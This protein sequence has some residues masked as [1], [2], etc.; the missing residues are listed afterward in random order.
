MCWRESNKSWSLMPGTWDQVGG[1]EKGTE[2]SSQRGGLCLKG[3]FVPSALMSG[4]K[5]F[6]K[7][8]IMKPSECTGEESIW[9]LLWG[10]RPTLHC[11]TFAF[12]SGPV[13]ISLI[14]IWGGITMSH[15]CGNSC[16]TEQWLSEKH[17]HFL[18]LVPK[19]GIGV[20]IEKKNS[21]LSK[22]PRNKGFK[23]QRWEKV[24]LSPVRIAS[25]E[26]PCPHVTD[27][28]RPPANMLNYSLVEDNGEPLSWR[29]R[30]KRQCPSQ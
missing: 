14:G 1:R 17:S 21:N 20:Y 10:D 3:S 18:P 16:C 28:I 27:P 25:T 24:N 2:M 23:I 19:V 9:F 11:L 12:S 4:T 6:P 5:S 8:L 30:R 7:A 26:F 22:L 29:G 13:L 15:T